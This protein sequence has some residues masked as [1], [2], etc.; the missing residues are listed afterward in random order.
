MKERDCETP[1]RLTPREL[2]F[3]RLR[4]TGLTNKDIAR[5]LYLS[6]STIECTINITLSKLDSRGNSHLAIYK[7]FQLGLI[8]YPV[9]NYKD[10]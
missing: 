3:L 6:L 9:R 4:F 10:A 2:E 5:R 8:E 7:A 1:F